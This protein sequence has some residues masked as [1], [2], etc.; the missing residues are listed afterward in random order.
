MF[1]AERTILA[2]LT[3]ICQQSH[4]ALDI[5]VVDD[6]STDRSASI[7]AAYAEQDRR[8]RLS[9]SRTRLLRTHAT[10][11]PLPPMRSF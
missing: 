11:A 3:S 9:G 7:V 8:I 1:N 6:G 4:Q 2:T 10:A 5:I